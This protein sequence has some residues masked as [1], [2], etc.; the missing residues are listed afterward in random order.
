VKP[1]SDVVEEV[2]LEDVNMEQEKTKFEESHRE[3]YE[4]EDDDHRRGHAHHAQGCR[5]Q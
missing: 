2:E 4:E 1:K 3:A 5:T